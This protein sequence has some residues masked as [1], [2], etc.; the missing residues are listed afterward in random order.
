MKK[1]IIN[2]IFV[3]LVAVLG[4]G[5]ATVNTYA[6]E[7]N[8]TE[9]SEQKEAPKTSLTLMPVSRTLQISSASTYDGTLSVINNG[10]EEIKV[11][12]YAAPYAFVYSQEENLYKLGFSTEN[13]FTQISRW[14]SIKD[15]DGNYVERPSF[16]IPA[17]ETLNIDY[18]VTTPNSIPAGGQ[19]AVIFVQTVSGDA[20]ASGIRTEASAGMVLYGHSTEGETIISANISDLEVGYGREAAGAQAASSNFYGSAKVKNDGN[21]DFF[22]RGVL[23][24]EPIIGFGSYETEGNDG[25]QS[26]IPESER[27]IEDEWTETPGFGLYK[28]TWTVTAGEETKTVDRLVFV[29]PLPF[30]IVMILL[31]TII[32]ALI[33]IGVRKRKERR[34]RL[35][36]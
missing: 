28:V 7:S 4:M 26:V 12:A 16:K 21:V 25:T 30:I 10:S 19:Y 17:G 2:S 14:I 34:S 18:K 20:N 3:G 5:L 15:T 13:K 22:A 36:V 35:A 31:L 8:D 33:I 29:N 9:S 32:I 23:K 6:D 24:V 27:V 1:A 11:E